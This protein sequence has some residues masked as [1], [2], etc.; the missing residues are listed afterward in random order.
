MSGD[1]GRM[2]WSW[3]MLTCIA[4]RNKSVTEA[5]QIDKD[6]RRADTQRTC[7]RRG[8]GRRRPCRRSRHRSRPP[9]RSPPAAARSEPHPGRHGTWRPASL[10]CVS[11]SIRRAGSGR[12][13]RVVVRGWFSWGWVGMECGWS[14]EW[15][16][17]LFGRRSGFPAL[18]RGSGVVSGEFVDGFKRGGF[19]GEF[20]GC[21]A[22]SSSLWTP[23]SATPHITHVAE[24]APGPRECGLRAGPGRAGKIWGPVW[25]FTM[26]PISLVNFN[27]WTLL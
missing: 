9:P 6:M 1:R 18:R 24:K 12:G 16:R 10:L 3:S 7:S 19:R 26:G 25:N 15:R 17:G 8:G 4:H 23:H 22:L 13:R 21:S 5:K 20:S 2:R 14:N 11:P 27:Y